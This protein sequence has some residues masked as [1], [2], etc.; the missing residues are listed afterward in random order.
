MS[1]NSL[2]DTVSI[3]ES[4]NL[5]LPIVIHVTEAYGGG[6]ATA[7]H[8]YIGSFPGGQHVLL[9][10]ARPGVEI[11]MSEEIS[12]LS[13]SIVWS[14][15]HRGRFQQLWALSRQFPNA[16]F[17]A[18]SSF[19]GMYV[20]LALRK[21]AHH[22]VYTPHAY[23]FE[24]RDIGYMA[25]AIFSM[26]ERLLSHNTSAVAACSERE[27]SVALLLNP[28]MSVVHVPNVPDS[29]WA[30]RNE[31]TAR[32]SK[33]SHGELSLVG[34]G[35]LSAQKDPAFFAKAVKALRRD[36][37]LRKAVWVGGSTD[38]D[39]SYEATLRDAGVEITGWVSQE[40]VKRHVEDA[41][42]YLHSASWEGFPLSVLDAVNIGMP[43]IVRDIPCFSNLTTILKID[44]PEDI[45]KVF[46]MESNLHSA[47][48]NLTAWKDSLVENTPEIQAQR[49]AL[50]YG[51]DSV[52]TA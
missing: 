36:G 15:T 18:H 21:K 2:T 51:M 28:R 8:Q 25:R 37:V 17:H 5:S 23:S 20:R 33:W 40:E 27:S 52:A 43:T 35:R 26:V 45:C 41:D 1:V 49:L 16:I 12:K 34:V 46:G 22:I 42:L 10:A 24:R 3:G 30:K 11:E 4:D 39:C 9:A 13:R 50:V 14:T 38:A 47:N 44:A 29:L 48:E 32:P 7:I 19:A 6:V 31:R